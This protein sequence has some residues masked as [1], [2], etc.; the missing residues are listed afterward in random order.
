VK[1]LPLSIALLAMPG[2]AR[3][4]DDEGDGERAAIQRLKYKMAHE[5]RLSLGAMPVDPFQKGWSGSLSYT[6]HFDYVAWEVFQVTGALL[7]STDLRN[8]LIDTFAIP[9][10]DFAAPRFAATTGLE[11]TPFYG[12]QALVND[13]ILH[14]SFIVGIHGGAVFGDRES[15]TKTLTDARPAIGAGL[16]WRF[17]LDKTF[18]LRIDARDFAAFRRAVRQ[19]EKFDVENVLLVTLS[20]SINMGRDDA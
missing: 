11:V 7:T 13:L 8:E 12:K 20:I 14:Q 19:N 5:L 15:I 2:L 16:G 6:V 1:A 17:F 18:S 10:E 4:A 3:A 9:P